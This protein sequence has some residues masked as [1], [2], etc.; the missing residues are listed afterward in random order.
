MAAFLIL[1][2]LVVAVIWFLRNDIACVSN[3]NVIEL[4]KPSLINSSDS[5]GSIVDKGN[6]V[7]DVTLKGGM[8][9]DGGVKTRLN[10]GKSKS[11]ELEYEVFFPSDFQWGGTCFGGKLPGFGFGSV[12]TGGSR[13]R[14]GASVR[15]MWRTNGVAEAYVYYPT[16]CRRWTIGSRGSGDVGN[17]LWRGTLGSFK[18]GQWN[19]VKIYV[20]KNWIRVKINENVQSGRFC[21]PRNVIRKAAV[22]LFHVFYGGKHACYNPSRDRVLSFRNMK[23]TLR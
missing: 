20:A 23:V 3:S 2:I 6:G 9:T 18:R 17:S 1:A 22:V 11:Y 5:R 13:L 16:T 7:Y 10:L 12:A 14:D 21:M 4:F 19:S 8:N 15:I